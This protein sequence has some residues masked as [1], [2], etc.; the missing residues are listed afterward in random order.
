MN[1]DELDKQQLFHLYLHGKLTED[2]ESI[3]IDWIN[4]SEKNLCSFK[5]YI[6]DNQSSQASSDA[7]ND[8]W[9]RLQQKLQSKSVD[10]TTKRIVFPEWIKM[11]AIFILAFLL[12]GTG[13][14]FFNNKPEPTKSPLLVEYVAPLGSRSFVK[15]PDGSKIWLN[16]GTTLAY[17]NNFGEENREV[18]LS[19]EAF[20]EIA[21]NPDIP[22]TVKT[23]DI[24]ITA[25]GTQFNVKAYAEEKTIETTLVEGSVKLEGNTFK[26]KE[27][28]ILTA[29]E[30]A[31]YTKHDQD[32][33][34]IDTNKKS[35]MASATT[36]KLKSEFKIVTSID[37]SPIISWKDERWIINNE[38]LGALSK[39]LER[40]YAVNFIFDNE[41]LKDYSF[42]GTLED[43]TLEQVLNA[44][45]A[46]SPINY[47][48]EGKTVYIMPDKQKMEKFNHLLMK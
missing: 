9:R 47:I 16:A 6:S 14:Y 13:H 42:G 21:K 46:S 4:S 37:P 41:L 39:K 3:L 35:A 22:F 26:L 43:E 31:V 48:I 27:D 30:K 1:Y 2:Q 5:K 23:S 29:Q 11:A 34:L 36:Q 38:K 32:I 40:R 25:L 20:F 33:D 7:T 8:A 10:T 17:E 19:G 18:N 12:G 28:V 15:M 44:I 24:N 45:R